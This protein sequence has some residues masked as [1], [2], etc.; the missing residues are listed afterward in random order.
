[1]PDEASILGF[2]NR[3]YQAAIDTAE[4]HTINDLQLRVV[5]APIVLMHP[6]P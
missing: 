4:T 6:M 3:W 1:M 5:S 2:T